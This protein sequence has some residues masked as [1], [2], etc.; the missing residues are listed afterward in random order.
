MKYHVIQK[1]A[2]L[3]IWLPSSRD[4]YRNSRIPEK[5]FL[6]KGKKYLAI[7]PIGLIFVLLWQQQKKQGSSL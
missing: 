4:K 5:V 3:Y 1:K 6:I 2:I 7:R